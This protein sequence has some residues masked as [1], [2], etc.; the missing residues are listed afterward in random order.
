[1]GPRGKGNGGGG[2]DEVKEGVTEVIKSNLG[3]RIGVRQT[4]SK[5]PIEVVGP[6]VLTRWNRDK[7]RGGK[8]RGFRHTL[9]GEFPQ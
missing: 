6:K 1:M 2:V 9:A 7:N 8:I 3:L 5:A 4:P